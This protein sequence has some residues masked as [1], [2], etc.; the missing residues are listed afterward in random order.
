VLCARAIPA[1]TNKTA[2]LLMYMEFEL[3]KTDLVWHFRR[4]G[5]SL[6]KEGVTF[7]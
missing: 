4:F 2:S 6:G 1:K 7:W 5:G 3:P